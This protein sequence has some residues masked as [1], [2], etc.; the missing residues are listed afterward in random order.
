MNIGFI[1]NWCNRG[2]GVISRWVR[3]IFDEAGHKTFV[4]ARPTNPKMIIGNYI[5]KRKEWL[6][7][8]ITYGS[9]FNMPEK[10]YLKWVMEYQID[11]V[12]CDMNLEFDVIKSIRKLGTKT[13]GRF[14]W[15]RFLPSYVNKAK[16]AYDVIYSLTKCEQKM[17]KK[18]GIFSPY[19]RFGLHPSLNKYSNNSKLEPIHFIFH[20]GLQG[21]RKPIVA[22]I[23]AFKSVSNKNI[24]LIIKSQGVRNNS[25]PVKIN[26]DKRISYI[27]DDMDESSY[28]NLFS[29]CHVCLSPSRWEGFGVHLY[30]SIAL[31]IPVISNNIPPINEVIKHKKSGLLVKSIP[32]FTKSNGLIAYN[33]DPDHLKKSITKLSNPEYLKKITNKT[34]KESEMD[35]FK[36]ENTK[37]DYLKV[38]FS[39]LSIFK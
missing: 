18:L 10:E 2:Q 1:T 17:Y 38:A 39:T 36:W 19:I 29:S 24:R 35:R 7:D 26:D 27:I 8:N 30:E 5:D 34:K 15:E 4:L 12:F 11:V 25:E 21:K 32:L 6:G 20:G 37:K 3:S 16:N 23:D 13:I 22:T 33:P 31:G 14:V 9:A 28:F